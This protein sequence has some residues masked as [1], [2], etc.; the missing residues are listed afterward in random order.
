MRSVADP[1]DFYP[2]AAKQ[3]GVA[4]KVVVQVAVDAGGQ[5]IDVRVLEVQPASPEYGFAEAAI[6]VA[7]RTKFT[8][9]RQEVSY[10]TFMVKFALQ[11]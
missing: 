6:E 5:P 2:A 9:P 11:N 3:Q 7:R 8:N 10:M 4:G 1:D